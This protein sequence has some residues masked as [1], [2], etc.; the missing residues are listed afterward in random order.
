MVVWF[1]DIQLLMNRFDWRKH[2]SQKVADD[3]VFGLRLMVKFSD[4][5]AEKSAMNAA[6][7]IKLVEDA[8]TK[9]QLQNR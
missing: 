9:H 4:V 3:K 7:I 2:S 8:Q 6:Q 5:Q 1:Q